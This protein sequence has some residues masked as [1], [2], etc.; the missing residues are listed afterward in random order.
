VNALEAIQTRR[1][2]R[3]YKSDPVDR[4]TIQKL[5]DAAVLA[6]SAKNSQTW[7]FTVVTGAKKEEMVSVIRAGMAARAAEGQEPGTA[8]WSIRCIEQA[9]VT[10]LVHNTDGI[11]PWKARKEHESW[12]DLATVQSVSAAIENMLLAATEFGLGSLW[13]ADIWEAYPEVNAWLGIDHQLVSAVAVGYPI[14]SPETPQRKP[15][16]EVVRWLD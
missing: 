11:H 14:S 1:S 15:M 8:K 5:L 10:I 3:K 16:S 9:P 2:I 13:I 12:W 7:R 6:P 4:D